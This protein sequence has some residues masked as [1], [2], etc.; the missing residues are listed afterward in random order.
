M[1]REIER[2]IHSL[3]LGNGGALTPAAVVD[4]AR[5]PTSPLHA[6]FEWDNTEAAH[7]YR[8]DQART[9][10]RS[11][12]IDVRINHVRVAAVAYVHDPDSKEAGYVPTISL[13]SD[14]DRSERAL[15][16][17]LLRARGAVERARII[18]LAIGLGDVVEQRLAQALGIDSEAAAAEIAA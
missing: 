5:D 1:N 14:R 4:A 12:R 3:T 16:A 9:L 15:E 18:A 7:Q 2:A 6:S 10:I 13:R 17:E 11:V 8:L